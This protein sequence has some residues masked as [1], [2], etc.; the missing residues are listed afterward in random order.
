MF[1]D[2]PFVPEPSQCIEL[3]KAADRVMVGF[4]AAPKAASA[5]SIMMP[6]ISCFLSGVGGSLPECVQQ[7]AGARRSLLASVQRLL[8]GPA[9][10]GANVAARGSVLVGEA[11]STVFGAIRV[12]FWAGGAR[13]A[14]DISR[15]AALLLQQCQGLLV[16]STMA[17][18][19]RER[20]KYPMSSVGV[21]QLLVVAD[22]LARLVEGASQI[23]FTYM[24]GAF[25]ADT[26]LYTQIAIVA[27]SQQ[28]LLALSAAVTRPAF[29]HDF[30]TEPP[31]SVQ[32][33]GPPVYSGAALLTQVA[34]ISAAALDD[35]P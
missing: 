4:A 24:N 10:T 34:M 3:V 1:G 31:G 32:Q 21:R 11:A 9:L 30:V 14:D 8:E 28:Q 12:A 17:A 27:A 5:A 18:Q 29:M 16:D 13:M 2:L 25:Q 22:L 26:R 20:Q 15:P 33:P 35:N 7:Q 6:H 23:V 19:L